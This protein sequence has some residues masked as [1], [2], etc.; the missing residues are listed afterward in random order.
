MSFARILRSSALMGGAQV[1][2][3][4]AGFVRAKAIALILGASGIGLIGIFNAFSGNIATFAGWGLGTSGVRLI[5]GASEEE[6]PA[7]VAAVR[8]MGWAL[9]LLGL[10]LGLLTFWPVGAATF[11]AG[12]Y[13]VEMAIV[14][15]AVPCVIASAAWSAILQASGK[16]ASLAKVQIA[17]ALTGLLLGLP[18]IYFW[19]TLGIALSI[20][21]AAAVPAFVLWRTARSEAAAGSLAQVE[22]ADLRQLVKLGGALMVVGWLG[23]L[24][25]YAVRLAIV[26]QEGLDAAGYYQAA[27]A[28]SGS[29]PGFIFAAMG[30]DFFPRV[31]AARDDKEAIG[32]TQIQIQAG[33]LLG[34]PL[35]ALLLLFGEVSIQML[36]ARGLAPATSLLPWMIWAVFMRVVSWPLGFWL[37][38]RGK[39]S[40]VVGLEA[41]SNVLLI[42]TSLF[43]TRAMGVLG[44]AVATFVAGLAYFIVLAFVAHRKA[45]GITGRRTWAGILLAS[46]ALGVAH[47]FSSTQSH[48]A[49]RIIYGVLLTCSAAWIYLKVT[50]P[51]PDVRVSD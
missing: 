10:A 7:K 13:A 9:S 50:R 14:A 23:Q 22:G 32:I 47:L 49:W 17:G 41:A 51:R 36:Y 12:Q 35:L 8:R 21:L 37:I 5:A 6:K 1:V 19:G 28:I 24:S 18:A 26:R 42:A 11:T 31:A 29:L 33:L 3:L 38:A 40:L 44:A 34:V 43:L 20:L 46:F 25:A 30:A 2:V 45:G 27:Y 39:P 4:A 16:I 48:V 15:L